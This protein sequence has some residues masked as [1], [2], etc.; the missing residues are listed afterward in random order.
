MR[1]SR[2]SVE[3]LYDGRLGQDIK[4]ARVR[5]NLSQ[6]RLG[7]E[8]GM[9]RDSIYRIETNRLSP[10]ITMLRRLA[11]ALSTTMTHLLRSAG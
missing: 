4:I 1:H 7:K 2:T 3:R 10:S 6:A 11:K 5:L 9:S 8:I